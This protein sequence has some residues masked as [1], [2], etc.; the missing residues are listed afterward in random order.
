[1]LVEIASASIEDLSGRI[2]DVIF[3]LVGKDKLAAIVKESPAG[4]L[5][6]AYIR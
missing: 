4:R 3:P 2:C 6:G 5:I 1:M